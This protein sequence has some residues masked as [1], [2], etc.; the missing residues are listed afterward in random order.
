MRGC[1]N[2]DMTENQVP[3]TAI[4]RW[5]ELVELILEA[6]HRYYDLDQ[7]TVADAD[8]DAL[9]VELEELESRYPQLASQDSPTA[10]VGGSPQ[11]A[12]TPVAHLAQMYSLEDVFTL[13]DVL[14]WRRKTQSEWPDEEVR[15]TAEVKVDGLAVN[16]TYQDGKL[17]QASTRGDGRVGEDV[18]A[19]VR[20]IR[21]IPAELDGTNHPSLVEIRGEVFFLLENFAKVNELRLEAGERAFVNP[22]N[23][24]A[25][26]LRQK[27]PEITAS[28]PLSMLAHGIGHVEPGDHFEAPATQMGWYRQLKEWGVPVSE[29][30][31]SVHTDEE[32]TD[33]IDSI[34]QKRGDIIHEID[35]VVLKVDDVAKQRQ[36]GATSRTPRWA[37]AYKYPPQEAFTRLLDIQVQVGRTGRVTPFAIFE[38]T[39]VD[40]SN[41]QHAT[42]HNQE[43]VARKQ[44]LIGDMVIIR[45]AGDV[46]PEVV[47]PVV[48][49]RDGTEKPFIM[50]TN[51]PSCGTE[52][53]PA[54]EGDVDLR[55]PNAAGCPAQISGRLSHLGSRGA[56]DVEG[57]GDESAIALT[58]P[59]LSRP[60]VVAALAEGFSVRLEDGTELQLPNAHEIAHGELFSEAEALLPPEQKPVLTSEKDVFA[61]SADSLRDVFVWRPIRKGGVPTGDWQQVRYF[62]SKPWRGQGE[63]QVPVDSVPRKNTLDLLGELEAAKTQELWRLIVALSIRH[64]GPTAAQA[65][66]NKFRSLELIAEASVEE[67]A[68]VDGVGPAIAESVHRWFRVDW[69]QQILA[70]WR[71]AGVVFDMDPADAIPQTLQGMTVVVSGSMPGHDRE[72]AK[73]AI[74][75]RG[76]KASASVSGKTSVLV[77]GP[78]A[79]SK[80]GRAREL[81]VP[82][83]SED[84][85]KDLLDS[86]AKILE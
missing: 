67:L 54:K 68:S 76:G 59:E 33:L 9:Y 36:L 84:R 34:G 49:D 42:L 4:S 50:P 85:F 80:L 66:A 71:G 38:K 47:G 73:Q 16:L 56:L 51:C 43:E 12:F 37:V 32:I 48:E 61:I 45:K 82:V 26:S 57:L 65:L 41:L 2:V 62:W 8:Y 10:T 70:A 30:T 19:N 24:A 79:G 63:K 7:P 28:R 21:T 13:D 69:H 15:F 72:S 44:V 39:L 23:A 6:R 29:H 3:Q 74:V 46:I 86:G 77:A 5:K 17:V 53:A 27:D 18:T 78:G 1:N 81:G 14:A 22:R 75:A 52:L 20:T 25:G 40:G 31:Q 83:L 35:G 64:V 58:Q 11:E 60:S 55:C